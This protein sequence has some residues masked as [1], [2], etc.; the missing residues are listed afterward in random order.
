ME[1]EINT[2]SDKWFNLLWN[3]AYKYGFATTQ[4]AYNESASEVLKGLKEMNDRF[5]KLAKNKYLVSDIITDVDVKNFACVT[6]HDHAYTVIFK[7]PDICIAQYLHI[8]SYI[9]RLVTK[10]LWL[11][12][13]MD[14]PDACRLY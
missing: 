5:A 10:Y 12:D 13:T 14:M 6:R 3:R 2:T 4:T 8:A 11:L 9:R 7:S 1:D